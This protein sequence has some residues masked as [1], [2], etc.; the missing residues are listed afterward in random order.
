MKISN[1]SKKVLASAL[2]AAMVVAFAPTVA[3]GAVAKNGVVN[4]EFDTTGAT[5]ASGSTELSGTY[6]ATATESNKL[7]LGDNFT[8]AHNYTYADG[9]AVTWYLDVDGEDG[10]DGG[11]KDIA[12]AA[13]NTLTLSADAQE[14]VVENSTI[15][16]KVAAQGT[17][18][19]V[20]KVTS[21]SQEYKG[22]ATIANGDKLAFNAKAATA[23]TGSVKAILTKD[24]SLVSSQ[25]INTIAASPASTINFTAAAADNVTGANAARVSDGYF[26]EESWGAGKWAM[27]IKDVKTD[28]VLGSTEFEVAKVSVAGLFGT[29][30][31][32][33]GKELLAVAGQTLE[34]QLN[35]AII[36]PGF[37]LNDDNINYDQAEGYKVDGKKAVKYDSSKWVKAGDKSV[38]VEAGMSLTPYYAGD[39]SVEKA[40][41]N[42]GA[43]TISVKTSGCNKAAGYTYTIEVS[44]AATA[45]VKA[46]AA[47]L[48]AG[49]AVAYSFGTAGAK[50]GTY[51]VTVTEKYDDGKSAPVTKTVGSTDVTLTEVTF[52]A[53]EGASFKPGVDTK[54]IVASDAKVFD[55]IAHAPASGDIKSAEGT[56]FVGWSLDGTKAYSD[57]KGKVGA[58]AITLTAL[59]A[60][61]VAKK[62]VVS[63]AD[64]KLT[65]SQENGAGYKVVYSTNGTTWYDYTAPITLDV[66]KNT[67]VRAKTVVTDTAI[68]VSESDPVTIVNYKA[69]KTEVESVVKGISNKATG[70]STTAA[71]QY[72][73]SVLPTLVSDATA[74]I[75]KIGFSADWK[76]EKLN[77]YKAALKTVADYETAQIDAYAAG[78]AQKDGS[79][80]KTD[81]ATVAKQ[82]ALI[83]DVVSDYAI[84]NDDKTT[85]RTTV[86]YGTSAGLDKFVANVT[87]ASKA[88]ADAAV[89]YAKADVDAAA[90]VTAQLK[91]AKTADELNA[92]IKAYGELND[93]QKQLV[94][95]AD[96]AAAQAALNKAELAEAQDE[97][98]IAAVK[99]KTVKAKAKKATKS[100]LKVVTSKSGAKSTF[101]KVTKNSKVTVSKS[102]KIVVKK[103][104]KAG[105]KY[106]VKVK[107][108]VGTQTKTVKVI[109]K[110]AK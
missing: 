39:L 45:T 47:A 19:A 73:K 71:P 64:G 58:S 4:V 63:Y 67:E 41:F 23:A 3:F 106:T 66:A 46:E 87:K 91:A 18:V 79:L 96:V 16:L 56:R 107:A 72:Y 2:S 85:E 98:A 40:V 93:T 27:T 68:K 51:T 101:K 97:A 102:G 35:A 7:F 38:K 8:A 57:S 10:Y 90:A 109:V 110:V 80:K 49:T 53:G 74:A 61:N 5:V 76:A 83:A 55:V 104:L 95:S 1:A 22:D 75:E 11:V 15:T 50:A 26:N 88:V 14:A 69:A 21:V 48:N 37:K 94:A 24:G 28:K 92:A 65:L 54:T 25:V 89:S 105:K 30:K 82:K 20:E 59:W 81:A 62:P 78:V 33:N 12:L 43:K 32:E 29:K 44:G 99:G 52:A 31:D 86:A 9:Q 70:A 17:A 36:T 60:N 108:T 103:G 84:Y 42:G 100:S 34:S 13:D 6:T 77:V